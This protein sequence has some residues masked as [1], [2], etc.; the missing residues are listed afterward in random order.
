MEKVGFAGS[1][2]WTRGEDDE[3]GARR[4]QRLAT[5]SAIYSH[6]MT[7]ADLIIV[8]GRSAYWRSIMSAV[9][10]AG[11]LVLCSSRAEPHKQLQVSEEASARF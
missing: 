10:L 3:E 9:G 1:M 5:G 8:Y 6:R 7:A 11:C 4:E 2:K